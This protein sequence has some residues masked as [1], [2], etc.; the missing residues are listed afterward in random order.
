[1]PSSPDC[2]T[3]SAPT[4]DLTPKLLRDFRPHGFEEVGHIGNGKA[5]SLQ[6]FVGHGWR[7]TDSHNLLG[8]CRDSAASLGFTTTCKTAGTAKLHA[9]R[10]R[11]CSL[12]VGLWLEI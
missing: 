9:S 12:W 6:R 4:A 2:F 7:V 5:A 1:M 8:R 10:A 11:H 3:L